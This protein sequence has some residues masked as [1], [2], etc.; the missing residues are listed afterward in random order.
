MN[1]ITI[2]LSVISLVLSLACAVFVFII[3]PQ[4]PAQPQQ[5]EPPVQSEGTA[6]QYV[7]YVGTNDKDTY[8]P[9]Y[10][11]EEAKKIVD[12]ICLKHFEGYTLQEATGSWID[13]NGITTHEYTIVCYFDGADEKTVYETAD[14]LLVA[15]NQNTI[16]V[17]SSTL[18]MDYYSGK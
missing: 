12:D 17:E 1:K 16:L 5:P 3:R 14:E 13:E 7:L 11:Q 8:A 6:T 18:E 9:K 2:V 15:L 4:Q 10:T